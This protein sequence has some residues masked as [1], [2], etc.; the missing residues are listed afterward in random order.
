MKPFARPISAGIVACVVLS[1]GVAVAL[2]STVTVDDGSVP[3]TASLR[4][5]DGPVSGEACYIS[6]AGLTRC[7]SLPSGR[8]C[9]AVSAFIGDAQALRLVRHAYLKQ[10]FASLQGRGA[11]YAQ[12]GRLGRALPILRKRQTE[13]EANQLAMLSRL[14]ISE[15]SSLL[16]RRALQATEASLKRARRF[17]YDSASGESQYVVPGANGAFCTLNVDKGR[18]SGMGCSKVGSSVEQNGTIA[19]SVTKGGY[20]LSG[21][22]PR[23][24]RKYRILDRN[25]RVREGSANRWGGFAIAGKGVLLRFEARMRSG[26]WRVIVDTPFPSLPRRRQRT[27]SGHASSSGR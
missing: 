22:L 21:L 27:P 12:S 26:E 4:A 24:A 5:C 2:A 10:V 15:Q 23:G 18:I 8:Y 19:M 3:A 7:P 9:T 13:A 20:E 1:V 16:I 11:L 14:A 25:R 17:Y 6:P